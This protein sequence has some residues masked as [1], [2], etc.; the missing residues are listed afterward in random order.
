M[1]LKRLFS[2]L[3]TLILVCSA[4]LTGCSGNK[5]TMFSDMKDIARIK[6]YEFTAEGSIAL[7]SNNEDDIPVDI[8][9]SMDGK[10]NGKAVA[11]NMS[12]GWG[13]ITYSLDDFIRMTDGTLYM[14]MSCIFSSLSAMFGGSDMMSGMKA[15]VSIPVSETSD[16]TQKLSLDFYDTIID[17][18][19]KACKDQEISQSGD[20]WTLN[21][22]GEQMVSFLQS[23]LEEIN[24]N[25]SSWYDLYVTLLEKSVNSEL[26]KDYAALFGEDSDEESANE[27]AK[28]PIQSLKDGK[29]DAVTK[30]GEKYTSYKENL[31]NLEK[32]ISSG[33]AK[34]SAKYDVS[35]TGKEGSRTAEQA[36]KFNLEDT[37]TTDSAAMT[38]N[39]K[40]TETGDVTVEAPNADDVMTFEEYSELISSFMGYISPLDDYSDDDYEDYSIGDEEA[41]AISSS[42]KNNQVYLYNSYYEDMK[43]YVLT[44]DADLYEIDTNIVDCN[45]DFWLKDSDSSYISVAYD[46]GSLTEDMETYYLEEGQKTSAMSTDIGDISYYT[47]AEVDEWDCYTTVFGIQLDGGNYLAGILELEKD[48]DVNAETCIKGLLKELKPYTAASSDTI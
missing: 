5:D 44:F 2:C 24:T 27:T 33:E 25:F 15:W 37:K 18:F 34:A 40:I 35:L 4:I 38:I 9:F 14:N 46:Q 11:A 45:M 21:I 29:K 17:S 13:A 32:S 26:L 42:L 16:E 43:P 39:H 36:I 22:S 20:T 47:A 31:D 10:T 12:I 8:S 41:A 6:T 28:D 7:D 48:A 30:W 3:I 23:G 19:E 1:K